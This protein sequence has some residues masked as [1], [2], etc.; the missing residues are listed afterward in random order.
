V[1][2]KCIHKVQIKMYIFLFM[3]RVGN[4]EE[5]INASYY[6]ET[7]KMSTYCEEGL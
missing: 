2:P 7:N 5:E 3:L 4:N 6:M 1:K